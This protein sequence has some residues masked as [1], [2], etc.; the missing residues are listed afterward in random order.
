VESL[1]KIYA[2]SIGFEYSYI[3]ES[4]VKEWLRNKI[5]KE[6]LA[7]NPSIDEKKQILQK[8]NEAVVFENFLGTKYLGQKRF[9]LEGG[10]STS[11]HLMLLSILRLILV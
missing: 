5:E 7:F 6:A 3:R 4:D 10:E 8:L 9:G 2:G 11:L 1:Y